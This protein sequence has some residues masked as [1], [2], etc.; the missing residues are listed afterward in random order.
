MRQVTLNMLRGGINRLRV[1]GGPSPNVLYDLENGYVTAANTAENRPGTV[2][3]ATLPA[4]TKGLCAFDDGLVVFSHTNPGA[5]P[6]GY[7][8]E[9][10]THPTNPTLALHDIHFAGPFLGALY[11]VA[12]FAGGDTF[13]Y[14]LQRRSVWSAS[15]T[16]G[17]GDLVE[18]TVP[19]GFAY[20][21]T[22]LNPAGVKWA[23]NVPRA[24]GNKVEP[25]VFNGY[26]FT[27]TA[28][29]GSAPK[30]GATEP[31][32]P[33]QSGATVYEDTDIGT[34]TGSGTGTLAPPTTALPTDVEDRYGSDIAGGFFK[35]VL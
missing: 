25:T 1:K 32:W 17:F 24:I 10:V 26:E 5:M 14:W 30:S 13:H 6:A 34:P 33:T 7:T 27:V 18:P 35:R 16:Y 4:G 3:D 21:A 31:N 11:V 29:A 12:E 2:N 8:C 22:R 23:P 9:I 20:R 28:V 15:K 19:N